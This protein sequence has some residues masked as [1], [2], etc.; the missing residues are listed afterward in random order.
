[1]RLKLVIVDDAPFIREVLRQLLETTD[2]DVIGEASDGE[3]AVTLAKT[4]V[5]DVIIMD[6]VMPRKSGIMAAKEILEE[7]PHI[8]IIACSTMEEEGLITQALSQGCSAY[9]TKPFRRQQLLD[10]IKEVTTE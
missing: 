2:I 8:K 1:M 10:K 6:L 3:Q 7:L 5:P 4:L 9:I